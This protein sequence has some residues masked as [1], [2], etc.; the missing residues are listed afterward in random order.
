M[1]GRLPGTASGQGRGDVPQGP[2][3]DG[4]AV[5]TRQWRWGTGVGVAGLVVFVL[6]MV[7]V[8]VGAFASDPTVR[9]R[10]VALFPWALGALGVGVAGMFLAGSRGASAEEEAGEEERSVTQED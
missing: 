8:L 2:R 1:D 5:R 3:T 4:G 7:A 10:C 9:E 6:L